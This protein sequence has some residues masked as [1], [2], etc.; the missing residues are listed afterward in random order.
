VVPVNTNR[1]EV[2]KMKKFP[3]LIILIAVLSIPLA[4]HPQDEG[5]ILKLKNQ[6]IDLQNKG[7]LGFK[8]VTIC[9]K[10]VGFGS[11]VP[12]ERPE[13]AQ[14]GE[15]LIYYEPINVFTNRVK[16][17]YEVWYSQDLILLSEDGQVLY[18]SEHLLDFHYMSRTPVFDLYAQNTLSLGNL[19]PGGYVYKAVLHDK[20]KDAAA[21]Y[22]LAFQIVK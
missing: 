1:K 8:D 22:S 7:K 18:E 12:T 2:Y 5:E 6:I 17:R 15:L 10:I 11:Y 9:S 13:V 4:S 20:L 14:G 3:L 21:E 19:P 16:G